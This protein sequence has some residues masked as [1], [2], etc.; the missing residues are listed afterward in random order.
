VRNS[1]FPAQFLSR[2]IMQSAIFIHNPSV[3]QLRCGIKRRHIPWNFICSLVGK[4]L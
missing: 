1:G 4:S 2:V 3:R